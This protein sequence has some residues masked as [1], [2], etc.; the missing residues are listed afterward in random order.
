MSA[1]LEIS[2]VT[3]Q[4]IGRTWAIHA[5][6]GSIRD[7]D[8]VGLSPY[9]RELVLW[10]LAATATLGSVFDS[11]D[12]A[13]ATFHPTELRPLTRD[14]AERVISIGARGK[15]LTHVDAPN[16]GQYRV[17]RE[18][19]REHLAALIEWLPDLDAIR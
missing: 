7:E 3:R 10:G 19:L 11:S 13:R 6:L 16:V 15:L 9:P 4:Y 8:Y 17:A 12:L 14:E 2:S 1:E 18:G 5:A